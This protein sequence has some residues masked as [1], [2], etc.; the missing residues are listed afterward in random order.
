MD[1]ILQIKINAKV[2][3]ENLKHNLRHA[4]KIEPDRMETM[5]EIDNAERE[6]RRLIAGHKKRGPKAKTSAQ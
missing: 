6:K 1:R 5:I 2:G 4:L 3:M